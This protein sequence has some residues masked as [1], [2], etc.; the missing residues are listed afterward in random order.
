MLKSTQ[1]WNCYLPIRLSWSWRFCKDSGPARASVGTL[2][3]RFPLNCRSCVNNQKVYELR[4]QQHSWKM[5]IPWFGWHDR[6]I[7]SHF[8]GGRRLGCR[9]D[10]VNRRNPFQGCVYYTHFHCVI[11]SYW[12]KG[13]STSYRGSACCV[14]ARE[15]CL[16]LVWFFMKELLIAVHVKY[17]LSTTF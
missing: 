2:V 16:N 1:H 4:W 3:K 13:I 10:I 15:F 6:I 5:F 9:C 11:Y 17:T 12:E 7:A 14:K 8:W